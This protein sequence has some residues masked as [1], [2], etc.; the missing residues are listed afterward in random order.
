MLAEA[1]AHGLL[2]D[3]P[4]RDALLPPRSADAP[5]PGAPP[6]HESL[7]RWWHLAE[8]VWKKRYDRE[9]KEEGPRMNLYARRGW[10]KEP[11]LVH[12]SAF[13][14]GTDYRKLIP[15]DAIT[16]GSRAETE[17]ESRSA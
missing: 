13:A 2:G 4:R 14:R 5:P 10:P 6:M 16:V 15:G 11:P 12:V 8:F 17:R 3:G 7:R 1:E 9:R